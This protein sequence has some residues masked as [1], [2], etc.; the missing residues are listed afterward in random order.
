MAWGKDNERTDRRSWMSRKDVLATALH[1]FFNILFSKSLIRIT[2]IIFFATT[3]SVAQLQQR[4]SED[5][6][7]LLC[8]KIIHWK[9][10]SWIGK[11]LRWEV[12][13]QEWGRAYLLFLLGSTRPIFARSRRLTW[14]SFFGKYP[15]DCLTR[16]GPNLTASAYFFLRR[17]HNPV[18]VFV[19]E[20]RH[21]DTGS[22]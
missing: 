7:I 1:S 21:A 14:L 12:D 13:V 6:L 8:P 18:L 9:L 20:D 15:I 4:A 16:I 2:V 3:K 22:Q 11:P 5:L 19:V 17:L 10:G